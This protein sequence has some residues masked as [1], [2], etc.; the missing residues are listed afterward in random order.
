MSYVVANIYFLIGFLWSGVQLD[1]F[2]TAVTNRPIV[3]TPGD[4]D[5]E[6]N[7]GLMIGKGIRR[8]WRKPAPVPLCPPQIPHE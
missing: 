6:E 3:S 8:T 1:P 5:D 2:G 7:G 4:Y